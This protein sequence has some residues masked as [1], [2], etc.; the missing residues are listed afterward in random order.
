MAS[1]SRLRIA[2]TVGLGALAVAGLSWLAGHLPGPGGFAFAWTVHFCLMAWMA[3]SL[4]AIQPR[5]ESGWYRVHPREFAFYRALGAFA[6]MRLLRRIGW[7]RLMKEK[8]SFKG[9]RATLAGLERDTRMS[10]CGHLILAVI[11]TVLAVV[12]VALD[13]W[14]AAAWLFGLNV[15]LHLYPVMLQ[16]AMRARLNRMG[17]SDVARRI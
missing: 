1:A 2:L 13:A 8:R 10:E 11:G 4:D 9:T 15:V 5:L 7:E 3:V 14:G 17:E 6:Y 12:A 16:R